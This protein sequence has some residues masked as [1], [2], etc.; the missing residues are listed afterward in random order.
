[1]VAKK[2]GPG[3]SSRDVAL[4]GPAKAQSTG[5]SWDK[6]AGMQRP[7]A[8]KGARGPRTS[9]A[10]EPHDGEVLA[11]VRSVN[12]NSSC[13]ATAEQIEA[14][15]GRP[16]GET[17]LMRLKVEGKLK[18]ENGLWWVVGIAALLSIC[19]HLFM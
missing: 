4:N 14:G 12:T 1:M 10:A 11:V 17:Q 3:F 18:K 19:P 5:G 15:V 8:R 9:T 6:A 2:K 13:G 7:D 16:L